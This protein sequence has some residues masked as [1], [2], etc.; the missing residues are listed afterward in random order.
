MTADQDQAR[1]RTE[2]RADELINFGRELF[3]REGLFAPETRLRKIV[4]A[5]LRTAG[6]ER[7]RAEIIDLFTMRVGYD[8]ETYERALRTSSIKN[9][10]RVGEKKPGLPARLNQ[11][12]T[13]TK[14]I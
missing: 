6:Y 12:P 5:G 4:R 11:N 10:A 9:I 2:A 13:T 3:E 1:G 8:I 14:E 7:T